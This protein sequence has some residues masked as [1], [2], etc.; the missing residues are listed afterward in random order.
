MKSKT[1]FSLSLLLPFALAFA[2]A[3]TTAPALIC[4]DDL[5]LIKGGWVESYL[6]GTLTFADLW[7][8]NDFS[9]TLGYNLLM[10]ADIKWF[11]MNS[12]ILALMNPFFILAS[13]LLFYQVYRKSLAPEHSPGFVALTFLALTFIIFSV[14]QWEVLIFGYALV[15]HSSMLFFIASFISL[16][17]FL[18][19]GQRKYLFLT[20]ALH[21]VAILVFGGKLYITYAPALGV[22]FLSYALI[23]SSGLAKSFWLRSLT[24]AVFLAII[25]WIY[26]YQLHQ[27]DYVAEHVFFIS[28]ILAHPFTAFQFILASFGA[29]IV[30]VDTFFACHYFSFH[31]IL[32]IGFLVVF[33]YIL[34]VFLFF[35][36]RM[37]DRTN[38][39]LF[40]IMQTL[41]YFGFMMIVRFGLGVDY[42]MASRYTYVSVCGLAAIVWIFIFVLTRPDKPKLI[43]KG[44]IYSGLA[45]IFSALLLSTVIEWHV[46]PFK[47]VE[48]TKL[49]N[50]A[51]R[52]DTA[53]AEELSLIWLWPEQARASLQILREHKLN[54]YRK[55]PSAVD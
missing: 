44:T 12:R 52:V 11:S 10:L 22:T 20:V 15:Y 5:S 47:K 7:R 28:G 9:R 41:F 54:V 17:L 46:R 29:S 37:Y 27:K 55:A 19:N 51:M 43:L 3:W 50:I 13:A 32:L 38:L 49:A 26:I 39:P 48:F 34:S 16:E 25:A 2:Y 42:G 6:N 36:S 31:S 23:K 45:I 1:L 18:V 40:L 14:I 4:R 21:A 30:S 33:Y 35:K 24:I 8:P 53:S